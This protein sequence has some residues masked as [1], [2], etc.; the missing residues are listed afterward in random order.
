MNKI[1]RNKGNSIIEI[2]IAI[3]IFA[4][5][6]PTLSILVI[7]GFS[8]TLRDSERFQADM[9]LQQGFEAMRSI[10]DYGYANLTTG[11]HGLTKTNGYW[12]LS[13]SS[14]TN[15]QFTREIVVE[16]VE[17]DSNCAIV[18]S[19]G[20]VDNNSKKITATITWD[21]EAGNSTSISTSQYLH[22]WTD[23]TGCNASDNFSVD[24]SSAYLSSG[25]KTINDIFIENTGGVGISIDKITVS[26]SGAPSGTDIKRI[27][28]DG[29]TLWSGNK[30]SGEVL[31]IENF[32]LDAGSGVYE[33]DQIRFDKSMVGTTV[34]LE[35]E[36]TDTSTATIPNIQF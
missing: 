25:N 18:A 36:M 24:T 27:K 17:R 28:I 13:G 6:F 34:S 7:G 30:G 23:A 35:F 10:R 20:K 19:G 33:I 8:T 22:N 2:I 5:V 4:L 31:N 16:E 15:G 1:K 11:T 32:T 26:W 21:I 3:G 12:E 9:Y 29:D 14:D